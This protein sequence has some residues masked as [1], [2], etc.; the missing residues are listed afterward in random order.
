MSNF[1]EVRVTP[2]HPTGRFT[3]A[4]L[5]FT[6]EWQLLKDLDDVPME[7]VP[8]AIEDEDWLMVRPYKGA[9]PTAEPETLDEIVPNTGVKKLVAMVKE[10]EGIERIELAEEILVIEQQ[11]EE[12]RGSLLAAMEE[13]AGKARKALEA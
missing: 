2:G 3:R 8:Q 9:A 5:T 12:P 13:L 7:S 1:W 4:G 11:G 10:R 6:A